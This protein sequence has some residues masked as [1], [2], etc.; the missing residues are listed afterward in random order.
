MQDSLINRKVKA[1]PKN[2][3]ISRTDEPRDIQPQVLHRQLTKGGYTA[4]LATD[5]IEG[6]ELILASFASGGRTYKT[7]L[8]D[9]E[10]PRLGGVEAVK[11]VRKMEASGRLPTRSRIIALTGNARSVRLPHCFIRSRLMRVLHVAGKS[12]ST[13]RSRRGW[14]MLCECLLHLSTAALLTYFLY[15]SQTV[16]K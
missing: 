11:R 1:T 5:G 4:D 13:M 2:D 15:Q 8:M 16:S 9:L 3:S 12:R 7:V 6:L 10:M 14:M